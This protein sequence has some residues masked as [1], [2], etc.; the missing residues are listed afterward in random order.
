MRAVRYDAFRAPPQVVDVDDPRCPDAGVVIDVAATGLCRSDWHAWMGHDPV[1]SL[2]H[3]PG[4]EF[5]GVVADVGAHVQ[6]W[7]RGDRVTVPFVC[8][9][10]ECD[11]CRRGEQQ[12]CEFQL[13]PGF[14]HWGSLAEMVAIDRAD[15]NLVRIPDAMDLETAASLGCRFSTA[16]RA[17][18]FHGRVAE[19]D[20]VVVHGCGGVGLSA[21]M[22][23]AA[24]G[25]RVIA[26]D[27]SPAALERA[28]RLGA[29]ET[30]DPTRTDVV[31]A[32]RD[33]TGGGARVSLDALGSLATFQSSIRGLRR[34]GRHIQVGLMVAEDAMPPLP[35]ADVIA[36]ELELFGS[37]GMA[38]HAYPA[39]LAEILDGT[40][41]PQRL[42]AHRLSLAD[43]AA[44]L[45]AL[46]EQSGG[47][48]TMV[49]P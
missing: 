45:A 48:I 42:V 4:H 13:Q 5:A 29:A 30:L 44:A 1:V 39:M 20:W 34:R 46:D 33:L 8:A 7:R 25:G 19:G 38:A 15:V 21:V 36:S 18:T 35:M 43:S 3:V 28:R 14:T 40:L 12:V 16:Y 32:V 37:H 11:T 17:V 24:H 23:A 27:V 47:G 26:V 41:A 2:P 22:I 9:C 31:A 10:G 6:S 49:I